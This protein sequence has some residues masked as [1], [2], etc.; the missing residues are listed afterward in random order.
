MF[1]EHKFKKILLALEER[2]FTD[3]AYSSRQ[4]LRSAGARVVGF[5]ARAINIRLLRS[6]L[7][8]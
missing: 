8:V 5:I 4:T 3:L 6:Q 1:V 7:V 2:N